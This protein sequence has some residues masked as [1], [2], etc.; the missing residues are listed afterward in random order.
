MKKYLALS[1][2][3]HAILDIALPGFCALLWLGGFPRWSTLGL[4]LLTVFAAYTAIYALNDLVGVMGDREKFAGGINAGYSVEASELRYPLA[5]QALRYRD[6][7]MWFALWF[8]IALVGSYL[9]NLAILIILV[10]AALLEVVY[11]LLFKVTYLR[12]LVSGLVKSAG[13]VA[14]V[15]TVDHHPATSLL[16]VIFAWVFFWEIGGQNIPADWNDTVEDRRV[17]AKTI[18]IH[19]G[20]QKAGLIVVVALSLT[21][22]TSLFL[23]VVS[24]VSLGV[25]YLVASL[26][27]GLFLLLRPAYRLYRHHQEGRLAARLFDNAS[28]YPLA[29]LALL[30]LFVMLNLFES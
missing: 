10:V 30:A 6:G 28:Y 29:Q 4:A 14:A 13:P 9:L 2:T 22:L 3:T 21:V 5:R 19:F 27:V 25:A 12:V 11:C 8:A 20:T 7:W 16:L 24:P 17:N 18:P 23:P 15:F 26:L 1:R